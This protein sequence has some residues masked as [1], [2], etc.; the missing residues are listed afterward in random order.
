MNVFDGLSGLVIDISYTHV[1]RLDFVTPDQVLALHAT[2]SGMSC[3]CESL[4]NNLGPFRN[5]LRGT[6]IDNRGGMPQEINVNNVDINCTRDTMK[7]RRQRTSRILIEDGFKDSFTPCVSECTASV[8]VSASYSALVT[9]FLTSVTELTQTSETML[10]E[11]TTDTPRD[12]STTLHSIPPL[13]ASIIQHSLPLT[14]SI[15]QHSL[16]LTT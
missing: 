10:L 13:T 4:I 12:L 9:S 7:L 15:I 3:S 1:S 11:A 16:P 2:G 8:P 5:K 6:C 14:T